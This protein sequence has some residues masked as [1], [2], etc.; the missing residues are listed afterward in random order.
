MM[1]S[2]FL[3]AL[4]T[5]TLKRE[6]R[7]ARVAI[8]TFAGNLKAGR[9]QGHEVVVIDV[10]SY[11]NGKTSFIDSLGIFPPAETF[12][13]AGCSVAAD[14]KPSKSTTRSRRRLLVF[15]R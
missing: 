5:E 4:K 2:R 7:N 11:R 10:A 15:R 8:V 6:I 1:T 13:A 14:K 9:A 3:R 12:Q